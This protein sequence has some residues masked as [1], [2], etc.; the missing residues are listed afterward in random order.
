MHETTLCGRVQWAL[1]SFNY[2][3]TTLR[4]HRARKPVLKARLRAPVQIHEGVRG[5]GDA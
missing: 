3:R 2:K 4:A 5:A 1:L